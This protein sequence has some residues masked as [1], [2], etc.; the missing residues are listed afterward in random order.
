MQ[1]DHC[2]YDHGPD[3]VVVDDTN[4][5]SMITATSSGNAG[6]GKRVLAPPPPNFSV[7]PPGYAAQPA[8]ASLANPPPPGVES[9][10]YPI[11]ST[12][13]SEGRLH[14]FLLHLLF[15]ARVIFLFRHCSL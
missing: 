15:F 6:V 7:P 10:V 5:S 14:M 4:L 3:P 11:G 9:S 13:Q 2:I 12:S 1:G 8:A